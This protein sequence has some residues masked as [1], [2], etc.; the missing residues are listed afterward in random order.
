MC[1]VSMVTD[2]WKDNNLPKYPNI[3][4]Y[5]NTGVAGWPPPQVSREEFEALRKDM[6]ELKEL[7][8]AAKKFD[9]ATN[10]HNCEKEENVKALI[11]IAK[12]LDVDF[13]DIFVYSD[14]TDPRQ[15]GKE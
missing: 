3:M 13:E 9:V 2:Y 14:E 8:I 4:T 12:V 1:T 5:P 6:Q 10:Q 11:R 7:L 15:P